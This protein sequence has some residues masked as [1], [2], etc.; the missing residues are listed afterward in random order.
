MIKPII[1]R[2]VNITSRVFDAYFNIVLTPFLNLMALLKNM[3]IFL[4]QALSGRIDP[5]D[6]FCAF[7]ALELNC[8]V[9]IHL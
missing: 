1:D 8:S 9:L 2:V 3:D 4:L 5:I 6:N 7:R